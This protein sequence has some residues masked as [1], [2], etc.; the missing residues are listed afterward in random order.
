MCLPEKK[1]AIK[2]INDEKKG[3]LAKAQINGMKNNVRSVST[4]RSLQIK[5][6]LRGVKNLNYR[7]V[8]TGN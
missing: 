6:R 7:V 4:E 3:S 2:P 5:F 1:K 8:A